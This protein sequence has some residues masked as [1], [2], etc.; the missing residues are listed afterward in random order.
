MIILDNNR[1]SY[2]TESCSCHK[3][4]QTYLYEPR[5]DAKE[6]C[7]AQA[8]VKRNLLPNRRPFQRSCALKLGLEKS[9]PLPPQPSKPLGQIINNP[10]V[11]AEPHIWRTFVAAWSSLLIKSQVSHIPLLWRRAP[12]VALR[13]L[14]V[15][16]YVL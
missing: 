2:G 9:F 14:F 11:C 13:V 4:E 1:Y 5:G 10:R 8:L 3:G 7:I 6:T 16:S 12:S 15:Y